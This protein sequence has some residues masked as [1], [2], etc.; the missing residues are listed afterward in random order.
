MAVTRKSLPGTE[1]WSVM[2]VL[3]TENLLL[4]LTDL[5]VS[6]LATSHVPVLSTAAAGAAWIAVLGARCRNSSIPVILS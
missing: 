1:S 5:S 3:V 6:Y 4:W 2:T